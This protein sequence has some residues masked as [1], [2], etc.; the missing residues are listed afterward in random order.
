MV[1][2]ELRVFAENLLSGM[3]VFKVRRR[4]LVVCFGFCLGW[5]LVRTERDFYC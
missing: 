1:G 4:G 3:L 2:L 5:S